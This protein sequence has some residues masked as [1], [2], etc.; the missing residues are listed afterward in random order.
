MLL[1]RFKCSIDLRKT[2]NGLYHGGLGNQRRTRYGQFHSV[3]T[4][5]SQK[6]IINLK[7]I[8]RNTEFS[9]WRPILNIIIG[10][11]TIH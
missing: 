10:L 2:L 3:T 9:F 6:S 4:T 11:V 7:K 5:R 1:P 8:V